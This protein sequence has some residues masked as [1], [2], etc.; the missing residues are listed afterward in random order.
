MQVATRQQTRN[1]Q[2]YKTLNKGGYKMRTIGMILLALIFVC[3]FSFA[4]DTMYI[5]KTGAL[6]TRLAVSDVDSISFMTSTETIKTPVLTTV[7]TNNITQYTAMSGGNV[8]SQGGSAIT[9]RGICWSTNPIPTTALETKTTDAGTTGEYSSSISGLNA[10]TKYFVRAYATNS[11][12]TSYGT[13]LSFTTKPLEIGFGG[14]IT[15]YTSNGITYVVH[16]FTYD[17]SFYPPTN[18]THARVLLVGSGGNGGGAD[19]DVGGGGGGGEVKE[20]DVNISGSSMPVAISKGGSTLTSFGGQSAING[21]TGGGGTGGNGGTSGNGKNGGIG[22]LKAGGGGGGGSYGQDG[23]TDNW[24]PIGG[25][26]GDGS[27]NDISGVSTYYG[28]GG[29]GGAWTGYSGKVGNGG[30]GGGGGLNTW[31]NTNKYN[32]LPNTGGGGCGAQYSSGGGYSGFTP[33]GTG[34]SGIVIISYPK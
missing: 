22:Q 33:G 27:I 24:N 4:Q 17:A 32:G 25:N 23:V 6:V 9:M 20:V 14:V 28:G 3:N 10:N 1:Q 8:T 11:F 7:T 30:A 26:G 13:E 34:G 29:G 12:G 21:E 31:D 19:W 16:T 5:Y 2:I 15:E 18:L